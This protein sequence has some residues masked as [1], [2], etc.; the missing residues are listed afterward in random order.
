MFR[1]STILRELVQ[2]LAKI[3]ILSKRSVK[4][5]GCILYGDVAACLET[6]R[7]L[8]VVHAATQPHNNNNDVISPNILT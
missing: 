3:K 8:F 6:A 7:V 2:S 1:S 5:F 4:F